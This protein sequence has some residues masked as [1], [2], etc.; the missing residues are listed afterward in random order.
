MP[1]IEMGDKTVELPDGKDLEREIAD[2]D[3][4]EFG[5][6][7]VP[8]EMD[9]MRVRAY[10]DSRGV[11]LENTLKGFGVKD[12]GRET[13]D[14]FLTNSG[15]KP[16]FSPV[17][18]AGFRQGMNL[19]I[20]DWQSLVAKT[21]PI[22][23]MSYECYTFENEDEEQFGL[24]YVG[25]G[26]PIPVATVSVSDKSYTLQKIGRGIEWSDESKMAPISLATMWFTELGRR[27]GIVFYEFA[28]DALLNGYFADGSDAPV[29]YSY[30]APLDYTDIIGAYLEH[31]DRYGYSPKRMICNRTTALSILSM[32]YPNNYPIFPQVMVDGKYPA[33]MG[34]P[35]ML[36]NTLANNTFL[37]VDTDFALMQLTA[38]PFSTEFDRTVKTQ[39]EGSY[40]TM[41]TLIAPLFREARMLVSPA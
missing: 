7:K 18:E 17:V 31:T 36:S 2:M 29:T 10:M 6:A 4:A 22:D 25:Q 41:I 23:R 11:D 26:A 8:S 35:M 5:Y 15:L 12:L 40:G 21:I 13:V 14:R 16:L 32:T 34:I 37:L 38:K 19:V 28:I 3:M 1:K 30:A 27:M 20:K 39:M 33:P 9:S 24:R